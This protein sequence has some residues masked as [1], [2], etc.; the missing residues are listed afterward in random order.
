MIFDIRTRF[1][2]DGI[3]KLLNEEDTSEWK[4]LNSIILI[5]QRWTESI[6]F[7]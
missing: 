5:A 4:G 7:K 3:F 2:N 6:L 1:E